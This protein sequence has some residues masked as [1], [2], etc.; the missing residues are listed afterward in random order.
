[1]WKQEWASKYA[2]E[3][4][5][6]GSICEKFACSHCAKEY[7]IGKNGEWSIR[8]HIEKSSHQKRKRIDPVEVVLW[9]EDW[10]ETYAEEGI[11][12]AETVSDECT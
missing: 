5:T 2:G 6:V 8:Q 10:A 1:M 3:G 4:I 11:E 7:V 9:K 12:A